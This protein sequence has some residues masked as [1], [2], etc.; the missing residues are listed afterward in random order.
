MGQSPKQKQTMSKGVANAGTSTVA[1][2]GSSPGHA[3]KPRGKS[4]RMPSGST[5]SRSPRSPAIPTAASASSTKA[6]KARPKSL[7]KTKETKGSKGQKNR[8]GSEGSGSEGDSISVP[9]SD[10]KT[11]KSRGDN[12]GRAT[13]ADL[14]VDHFQHFEASSC[15]EESHIALVDQC[16]QKKVDSTKKKERTERSQSVRA[17]AGSTDNSSSDEND[18]HTP[19]AKTVKSKKRSPEIEDENPSDDVAPPDLIESG[20]GKGGIW[21]QIEQMFC[22]I[23]KPLYRV[24][25]QRKRKRFQIERGNH[26]KHAAV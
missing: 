21:K 6:A 24:A 12:F 26:R 9:R 18:S 13:H 15:I 23:P 19:S 14:N 3:L 17:D 1:S 25:R 22:A 2:T 20:K 11:A 4:S 8:D 16:N 10:S 5:N 7:P